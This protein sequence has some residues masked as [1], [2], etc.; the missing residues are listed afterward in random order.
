[1]CGAA[2]VDGACVELHRPARSV[3]VCALATVACAS[4]GIPAALAASSENAAGGAHGC[5]HVTSAHE[6]SP[7]SG[8]HRCGHYPRTVHLAPCAGATLRPSR[9]DIARIR[10]A[11]VCLVNHARITHGEAPLRV[12]PRLQ[13]AAQMHTESMVS[14]DYFEHVSPSGQTPAARMKKVGYIA[15]RHVGYE[16][17]ENIGLGTLWLATPSAIVRAWMHSPGHRANIL[18]PRFR[19]TAVG[20]SPHPPA[21]LSHGQHGA[22]Y[23]ED[24]GV[25]RHPRRHR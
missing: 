18:D 20:V 21:R 6:G 25:I 7:S 4:A 13:R 1:M 12:N 10:A 19:D 9:H 2:R 3:V 8:Q 11:T 5:A 14:R 24:F 15:S 23:T 16:V 22:V 17:G